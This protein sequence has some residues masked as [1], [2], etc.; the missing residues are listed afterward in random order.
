MDLRYTTLGIVAKFFFRTPAV[1]IRVTPDRGPSRRFRILPAAARAGFLLSP[2]VVT[3]SDF[4]QLFDARGR[5]A[6]PH[7]RSITIDPEPFERYFEPAQITLE[8]MT[9]LSVPDAGLRSR[10]LPSP[11]PH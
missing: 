10:G 3:N 1:Y 7:V 9:L 8:P 4:E 11:S 5:A 2:L 6:L